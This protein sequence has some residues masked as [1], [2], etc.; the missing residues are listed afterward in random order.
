MFYRLTISALFCVALAA[1]GGGGGDT[2]TSSSSGSSSTTTTATT[3]PKVDIF[4]NG[5]TATIDQVGSYELLVTGNDNVLTVAA[6]DGITVLS[7]TGVGNTITL[8]A[9]ATVNSIDITGTGNTI[10]LPATQ[11]PALSITGINNQVINRP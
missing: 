4:A 7:V 5:T 10:S 9:G 8:L 1:C 3:T 6:G 2:S 11:K